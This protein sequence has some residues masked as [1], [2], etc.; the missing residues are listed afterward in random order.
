MNPSALTPPRI[1]R[2][3]PTYWTTMVVEGVRHLVHGMVQPGRDE[4]NRITFRTE[5]GQ[6]LL[7]AKT[8]GEDE[9]KAIDC[10]PCF[11]RFTPEGVRRA[12]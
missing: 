11:D 12:P 7:Y 2:K 6:D 4:N 10:D 8:L 3:I 1:H 5:C 9:A